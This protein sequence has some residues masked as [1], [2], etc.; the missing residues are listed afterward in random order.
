MRFFGKYVE[1][2]NGKK[3]LADDLIVH[4]T[5]LGLIF[6]FVLGLAIARLFFWNK[7]KDKV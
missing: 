1:S 7:V 5:L 6:I 4:L 3:S 2:N